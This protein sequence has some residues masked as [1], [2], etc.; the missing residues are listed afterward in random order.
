MYSL[1]SMQVNILYPLVC[2]KLKLTILFFYFSIMNS[3]KILFVNSPTHIPK[4][5]TYTV[6]FLF[7]I[8]KSSINKF[9]KISFLK[10]A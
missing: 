7:E 5:F 9:T 4:G 3:V 2:I 1:V 10:K 6:K 8:L